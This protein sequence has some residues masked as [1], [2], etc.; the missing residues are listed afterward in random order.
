MWPVGKKR[1]TKQMFDIIFESHWNRN[2]ESISRIG[3]DKI[4]TIQNPTTD[5]CL[6][7]GDGV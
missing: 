6:I 2:V 5:A 1:G 3:I 7:S 4:Q